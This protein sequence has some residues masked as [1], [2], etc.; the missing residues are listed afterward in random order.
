MTQIWNDKA[1]IA[2]QVAI[3]L[4]TPERAA[5]VPMAQWQEIFCAARALSLNGSVAVRLSDAAGRGHWA[6]P[7][8]L[9]PLIHDA[10][11]TYDHIARVAKWEAQCAAHAL[12]G[13]TDK[14]VLLKGTAYA[15]ADM[16]AA[17]GRNIGDLDILVARDDLDAVE[18]A[19]LSH[20]WEWVK[21][22][23]YDDHYYR[24][25]MH[26]LPPLIHEERDNMIDIHHTILPLTAKPQPKADRMLADAVQLDNGHY[27]LCPVDMICHAVAH[28]LA[29]GDLAGGMRN[30]WDI[31]RMLRDFA[32][33][34]ALFWQKLHERAVLHGLLPHVSRA[35][36]LSR[37][38]YDTPVDR[39][40]AGRAQLSDGAFLRCILA[41]NGWGQKTRA[42]T[43]KAFYLRSHFLRMPPMMLARHLWTKW[44]KGHMP[45]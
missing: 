26:E 32:A 29:D 28:M 2:Q 43:R 10:M 17:Q 34:D 27:V 14:M 24:T 39:D 30:L 22:D 4:V 40:L 38:L 9:A 16:P 19:A 12:Q 36:R 33:D 42:F 35:L 6:I 8:N 20:G 13:A 1:P 31:D 45:Q 18:Q 21:P 5:Q 37:R 11:L 23:P 41:V 44:R 25:W 3:L 15:M 7:D